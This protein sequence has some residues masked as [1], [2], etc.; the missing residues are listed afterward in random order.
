MGDLLS[1]TRGKPPAGYLQISDADLEKH[2]V[3]AV[4]LRADVTT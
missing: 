4:G 1:I 3:D 2:L